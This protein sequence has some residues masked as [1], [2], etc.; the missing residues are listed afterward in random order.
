[1]IMAGSWSVLYTHSV[2][3]SCGNT[4][5]L[6]PHFSPFSFLLIDNWITALLFNPKQGALLAHLSTSPA[7]DPFPGQ[8]RCRECVWGGKVSFQTQIARGR[9]GESLSCSPG[10]ACAVPGSLSLPLLSSK[11]HL[12]PLIWER[13]NPVWPS[14]TLEIQPTHV[15]CQSWC[16]QLP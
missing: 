5:L 10:A 11:P 16:W 14:S 7:E 1:M 3:H 13:K 15:L 6:C 12:Q 9:A 8:H 4:N 2:T